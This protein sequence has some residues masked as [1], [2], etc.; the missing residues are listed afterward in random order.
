MYKYACLNAIS[1]KGTD[2]FSDDYQR[3][4]DLQEAD[5]ILVRSAKIERWLSPAPVQVSTISRSRNMQSRA[6]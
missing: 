4:E 6:S 3:T 5:A 2:Q 1:P